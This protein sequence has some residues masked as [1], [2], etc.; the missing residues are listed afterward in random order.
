M[1][2]LIIYLLLGYVGYEAYE[3]WA[4]RQDP[5]FTKAE[6][7]MQAVWDDDRLTLNAITADGVKLGATSPKIKGQ[8]RWDFDRVLSRTVDARGV[9]TLRINQS[10]RYDPPGKNTFFG[11]N[12]ANILH[13]II[14][15]SNRGEWKV[16]SYEFQE[17]F[18][19]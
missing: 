16:R 13:T 17:Y 18:D 5:V 15:E 7:C 10:L 12:S 3:M 14:L 4:I 11:E 9:E 19:R 6:E 2:K 8:K 1:R